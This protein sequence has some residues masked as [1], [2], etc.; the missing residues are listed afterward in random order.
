M[1]FPGGASIIESISYL[2]KDD[3]NGPG[4][5][6]FLKKTG[7]R[8]IDYA[9]FKISS[10][11]QSSEQSERVKFSKDLE[12]LM[13]MLGSSNLNYLFSSLEKLVIQI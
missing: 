10:Y 2:D 6:H 3:I 4:L 1:E 13:Q 8:S 5:C 12:D 11:I 9:I 7:D